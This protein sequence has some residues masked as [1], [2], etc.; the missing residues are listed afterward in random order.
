MEVVKKKK[1]NFLISKGLLK[2]LW[3]NLFFEITV[4]GTSDTQV[5][6]AV[7]I[8]KQSSFPNMKRKLSG[9]HFDGDDDHFLEVQHAGFFKEGKPMLYMTLN[10]ECKC[11]ECW[12]NK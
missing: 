2:E 11:K 8:I 5:D 12:K 9:C 4:Q 7:V 6:D 10:S 3:G 1:I